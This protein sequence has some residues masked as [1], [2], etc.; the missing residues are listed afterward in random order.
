VGDILETVSMVERLQP[1]V[2]VLDLMMP[3]LNEPEV[4]RV[5]PQCA[6]RTRAILAK[7]LLCAVAAGRAAA[8]I[9]SCG[10]LSSRMRLVRPR[11]WR[12]GGSWTLSSGG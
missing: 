6:P 7:Q 12:A 9:A 8:A 3:G 1:D 4:L 2:Q 11:I 10:A 5:I